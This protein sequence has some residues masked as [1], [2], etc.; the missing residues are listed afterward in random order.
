VIV[1][2][3]IPT[4][5]ETF[6]DGNGAVVRFLGVVR[7]DGDQPRVRSIFYD[8]YPPMAQRVI[9]DIVA[10]ARQR[11]RIDTAAIVHRVGDVPVGEASLLVEVRAKHRGDSFDA[12]KWIVEE[13]KHRLPIWKREEY[14]DGSSRWL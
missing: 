1:R 3:P 9:D 5:P 13:I 6:E 8:A 14:D 2:G 12:L 11:H 4:Q 10:M 7:G